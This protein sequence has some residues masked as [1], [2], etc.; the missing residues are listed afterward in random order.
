MEFL[1]Y[2]LNGHVIAA[3]SPATESIDNVIA[4]EKGGAAAVI[5]KTTS[6]HREN[7]R[8]R[9]IC[10][11]DEMG[12]WAESGFDREILSLQNGIDLVNGCSN[13][14]SIPI[15]AS[16]T[17]PTLVIDPWLKSASLLE[18]AGANAIH[19]DFFYIDSLICEPNFESKFVALLCE[20]I[21]NISVP[22]MPKLNISLPAAYSAQLLKKAEVQY[23]SL[24]DSIRSPAPKGADH[25]T[26]NGLSVFGKFMLPIT[27]MY[28]STLVRS[29]FFVCAGGGIQNG[30]DAS[31]LLQLGAITVQLA[32]DVLLN[33]F[34]RFSAIEGELEQ[35]DL[36]KRIFSG[37]RRQAVFDSSRCTG[38]RNCE[39][40]AF[41]SLPSRRATANFHGCEGCGLCSLLCASGAISMQ[42]PM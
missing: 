41:C 10:H 30:R 3:S 32:S 36:P 6:S 1:G 21:R 22:I 35:N 28:T 34:G 17:E 7:D 14:V 15:I 26:G 8:Q 39:K 24:L 37:F 16:V 5:L 2:S 20:L 27:R 38:C 29:G 19:L 40:Q 9:R 4:C 25:L 12:F 18:K 23:V 31:D 13:T 42:A 11:I 33:G